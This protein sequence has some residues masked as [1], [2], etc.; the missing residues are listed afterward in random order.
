MSI[1]CGTN[2]TVENLFYTCDVLG[3]MLTPARTFTET[4]T[5]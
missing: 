4:L 5:T 1:L 3:N 2:N